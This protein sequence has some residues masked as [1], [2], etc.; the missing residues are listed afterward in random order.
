MSET[1]ADHVR[2]WHVELIPFTIVDQTFLAIDPG[3]LPT[4][5]LIPMVPTLATPRGPGGGNGLL[6]NRFI[7]FKWYTNNSYRNIKLLT[8]QTSRGHILN[9]DFEPVIIPCFQAFP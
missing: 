5:T 3:F 2:P 7:I 4:R 1:V 9:Q 8:P 6:N